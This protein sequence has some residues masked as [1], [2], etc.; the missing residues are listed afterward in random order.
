M[1]TIAFFSSEWITLEEYLTANEYN[2]G[3]TTT[4]NK[5]AKAMVLGENKKVQMLE[6]TELKDEDMPID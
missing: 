5:I 3:Q 4:E 1:Q 2:Y 6:V